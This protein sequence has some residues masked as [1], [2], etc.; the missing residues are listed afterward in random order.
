MMTPNAIKNLIS[1]QLP[2]QGLSGGRSI[3]ISGTVPVQ[4]DGREIGR[5]AFEWVD[6]FAGVAY[7][8]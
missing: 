7:G 6:T 2:A 5:T 8:L 3:V 4:I 1:A